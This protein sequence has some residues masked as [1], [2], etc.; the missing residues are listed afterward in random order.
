MPIVTH[1]DEKIL[2]SLEI[3]IAKMMQDMSKQERKI[4]KKEDKLAD[5]Y[6]DYNR[7]LEKYARKMRDLS[8][9]LETLSREEKSGVTKDDVQFNKDRINHIEEKVEM[10]EKYYDALKDLILQK[11][12]LWE[13]RI[14]YS[15][16][17]I[18]AAKL[19][20]DIVDVGLKIEEAKNK[21]VP[22]EKVADK[23]MELKE[24]Q[25]EFDRAQKDMEKKWEQLERERDE[26][27]SIWKK[28]KDSIPSDGMA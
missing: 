14:E 8:K 22:A 5:K 3:E 25:R 24:L 6:L 11:E 21:M 27:N 9:Q 16:I 13:K 15:E 17:L 4:A 20:N 1:Q 28:I 19:R 2:S 26:V 12:S 10:Q 23:E 7:F 18:D